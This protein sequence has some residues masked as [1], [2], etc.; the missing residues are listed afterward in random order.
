VVERQ[1]EH[2]RVHPREDEPVDLT[3]ALGMHEAVEIEPLVASAK[4]CRKGAERVPWVFVREV[5]TPSSPQAS[6]PTSSRPGPTPQPRGVRMPLSDLP[7]P[8]GKLFLKASKCSEASASALEGRGT[9]GVCPSFLR[10]SHPLCALSPHRPVL[11]SIHS[12]TFLEFHIPPSG[13]GFCSATDNSRCSEGESKAE[14][15]GFRWRRS[16][17]P[18]APSS[19]MSGGRS[20]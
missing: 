14:A 5:P 2:L 8:T 16:P 1:R 15:P 13:G 18:W 17:S 11:C 4:G 9:C 7:Q 12:T 19:L 6:S 3:A 20:P 10:Y